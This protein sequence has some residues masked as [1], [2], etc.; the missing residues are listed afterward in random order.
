MAEYIFAGLPL[1]P[2]ASGSVPIRPM[3]RNNLN[4]GTG[5]LSGSFPLSLI[6]QGGNLPSHADIR[7]LYRPEQGTTGDGYVVA[8]TTCNVDGSWQVSGLNENFKFDIVARIRGFNDVIISNVQPLGAPLSAHFANL[9]EE[10]EYGEEVNIQVVALGGR[11]PYR[12]QVITLPEG[13]SINP[14]T[15]YITGTFGNSGELLFEF[16]ISDSEGTQ[17]PL[18]GASYVDGDPHWDKVVALLH[19]DGDFVDVSQ[20]PKVFTPHVGATTSTEQK[21]FGKASCYLNTG[22]LIATSQDFDLLGAMSPYTIEMWIRPSS[23]GKWILSTGGGRVGWNSTDGIHLLITTNEGTLNFQVSSGVSKP[24]DFHHTS[25]ILVNQWSFVAVSYDGNGKFYL[26]V[27]G[28]VES[29]S[30]TPTRPTG[31]PILEVGSVFGSSLGSYT[32]SGY[33]DELRITKGI[34]RYTEDFTP[35]TAPFPNF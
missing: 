35:P 13:L 24:F 22:K 20:Y 7:I 23:T 21:V 8:T 11:P 2:R 9:K 10:Y 18:T 26:S 30:A 14:D 31:N 25:G 15:G 17:I 32:Y 12:Y 5:L 4:K 19:F 1:M 29:F 33:I 27:G 3:I 28:E 34:A 6:T 16:L